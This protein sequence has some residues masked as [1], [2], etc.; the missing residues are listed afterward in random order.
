MALAR[1]ARREAE[2]LF[3]GM[4]SAQ[5]EGGGGIENFHF[6]V[7]LLTRAISVSPS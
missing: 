2:W 4:W 3:L 7:F 6:M 1:R 5:G